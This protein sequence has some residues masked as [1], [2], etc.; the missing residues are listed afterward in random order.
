MSSPE[1]TT[2]G[3]GLAE[4]YRVLLDIGHKLARTLS[5]AELYQAIYAETSRVLETTGFYVAVYDSDADLATVVFYAD[6]GVERS[7]EITYKGSESDVLRLGKSSMVSDRAENLS[8]MVLGE[9]GTELTRS[10][11]SVPLLYEGTVMGALSAQSYQPNQYTEEDL[12]LFQAIADLAVVAINNSRHV[13]QLESRRREAERIEEIGRAVAGSLDAKEVLRTVNDAVL[14]LLQADASTV[15]LLEGGQAKV[16]SSLGKIRLQEGTLWSLSDG[17]HQAVIRDRRPLVIEDLSK[18]QLIPPDLA[19]ETRAGSLL[20]VPLILEDEVAGALSASKVQKGAIPTEE[21]EVLQRLA[22]Q[23]SVALSNARLH[24]SI[25]NLSLTDPLTDLPNRRHL[26]LHL[27]REVAAARRGR[28]VCVCLF[29]LN[30]FKKHNDRLGHVVGDQILRHFGR[31][32]LSETRAMNLAARYGGDEFITVLTDIPR[33]GA[34]SQAKRVERRV[35][36]HPELS[37]Y[38]VTI[39]FGIAEFDPVKMFEV[40]DLVEEADRDLYRAKQARGKENQSR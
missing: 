33:N 7:V 3:K 34:E 1:P 40:E 38:G 12:E 8:L 27:R 19:S 32:L 29:D 14:E 16:A 25:R 6:R 10:A 4:R 15:W 28:N 37:K 9:E 36:A 21:V 31:I 39:S 22:N 13:T 5:Q 26:D 24:E 11:L 23:T 2:A 30:D 18:S 35:A 20:L 17:L